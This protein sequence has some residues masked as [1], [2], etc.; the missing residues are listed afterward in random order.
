MKTFESYDS[1]HKDYAWKISKNL[2]VTL[3]I[4]KLS[5]WGFHLMKEYKSVSV[6]FNSFTW[7]LH[8]NPNYRIVV[9]T[10]EVNNG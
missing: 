7:K 5:P 6:R 9:R 8:T 1:N 10:K 4:N 2:H 3:H